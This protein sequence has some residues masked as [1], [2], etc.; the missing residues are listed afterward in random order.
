MMFDVR[1]DPVAARSPETIVRL[2]HAID[3]YLGAR[4]DTR[5]RL[6]RVLAEEPD[7][8]LARCLDGYLHMLSS[9]SEGVARARDVVATT[10]APTSWR[11][12]LHMH[13][14]DAWS[15]GDMR[16][17]AR[18][19]DVLL[20]DHPRDLMALKVSQF[21]LSYLGDSQRMRDTVERVLP[22]WTPD[23]P[24]YGFVLGC[25]AYALEETGD[26][27]HAEAAGRRAVELNPAD[28]W[29]AHAVAHVREMECRL[30]EG[31]DWI[32]A[33]SEQWRACTNFAMHLRW[34]EA[35]FHLELEAH[36]RVL[37]L[38]DRE[39]RAQ[40]T[41]EYL[42]VTN[43]VSLLWRL[44]QAGVDVGARWRELAQR[45]SEHVYDHTL[46]FVDAHYAMALAA[47]GDHARLDDFIAS[48]AE[49]A[50][51]SQGT[52]G[53]VMREV[54]LSLV[55]AAVAHRRG[56]FGDVVE[57][58]RPIHGD[59]RR[60]GGS[61]AQRDVFAQMLIDAAWR[62]GHLEVANELLAERIARRPRN[63]W[64]WK[65]RALVLSALDSPLALDAH[66][67]LDRLRAH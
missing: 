41:D 25:H 5:E 13:A 62:G 56:S 34:H 33:L 29:A 37:E 3:A 66:R 65:H 55:R 21:V 20:G 43:A 32:V 39:V 31:I 36:A 67:E 14:L 10:T 8:V 24:G 49:F 1:G 17:A 38:Y 19:L 53:A 45:A 7:N 61:H 48:C 6:D 51:T 12:A 52:E 42:D 22:A 11:E 27:A 2:D 44:E 28:I 58:L 18:R 50:R 16:E 9:K 63:V 57:L 64:G 30:H 60:I 4:A 59:V 46:V 47:A 35:L 26:Y 40:S 23:V 54:G 15:Q